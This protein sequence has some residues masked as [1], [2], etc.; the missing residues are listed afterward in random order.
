MPLSEEEA[1]KGSGLPGVMPVVLDHIGC[2]WKKGV[3][4]VLRMGMLSP[5]TQS[6]GMG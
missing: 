3:R 2:R 4:K 1:T 5:V 6:T